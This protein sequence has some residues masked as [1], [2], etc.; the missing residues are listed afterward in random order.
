MPHLPGLSSPFLDTAAPPARPAR[1]LRRKRRSALP[2]F[3]AL[4]R[5]QRAAVRLPASRSLLVLGEAGHGKTTV[6]LHRVAHLWKSAKTRL[7]ALVVVPNE[8]LVRSM[9]PMLRRL[10]VD[11]DVLTYDRWAHL[12]ARRAFRRLPKESEATPPSVM[13]LK[14]HAA[15]RPVIVELA[16]RDPSVVD[17]DL[18]ARRAWDR[19]LATRGD[20]Q[21]LFG[22]RVLLEGVARDAG[23][24][25]HIVEDT[26]DRTRV[27]FT[28]TAEEEFA[29]VTDRQRLRTV[30]GRSLDAGTAQE[31]AGTIDVEDYAVLFELDRLRAASRGVPP[32]KRV[33]YDL[34]ALDE[35]QELAPLE[36]S[37][38]GA[39]L[40]PGGTLVVAGDA[41]QQ[42]D[43]TTS[44]AG[45]ERTMRE[46]G[47]P[48]HETVVLEMGYRCAPPVVALARAVR[49]GGV[50][51]GHAARTFLDEAQLAAHLASN[52]REILRRDRHASIAVVCR[53][54]MTA[55]RLTERLHQL[56]L[57]ARLV[58]DG[59][60]LPRGPVQLTVVEEVKGLEFDFVFVP[61]TGRLTY[62]DDPASRRALYV[63]VTRARYEVGLA[64]TGEPSPILSA[65]SRRS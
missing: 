19:G 61:D 65:V 57:P 49:D 23:L 50:A 18:D 21:H 12:Q 35:A 2:G 11:V 32:A 43:P 52:V 38:L 45:W 3:R 56:E 33:L 7:R 22:D 64:C 59:R 27:Q 16:G 9:Q 30:D 13:R 44:F 39:S 60:F 17:C 10:G 6:L 62:P 51:P 25:A 4:D 26:L 20:L 48:G 42:T 55:R 63:A 54:P 53:A 58:F 1:T 36:L 14:R 29:H 37:L 8:G 28:L 40:A 5:A 46:L 24:G 31:N 15:L 41:D 47:A 34:V